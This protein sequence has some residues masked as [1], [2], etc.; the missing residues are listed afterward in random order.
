MLFG[1]SGVELA[2]IIVFLCLITGIMSGFPVA[3]ALGGSAL[4]SFAII[5]VMN[6]NGLLLT[7]T[8]DPIIRTGEEW[9]IFTVYPGSAVSNMFSRIFGGGNVDVLLAVPLFVFMGIT[10]ERSHIADDLL[11]TMAKVFGPLPGGLA[12]SVVMVGAL[13]AASTGIVGAT[14]VTMGLLSLPTMLNKGYSPEL[15][16]GTICASGTLG[17][18]IPPSIVLVLLGQQV[19]EYYAEAHPGTVVS[20]GTLF[21]AAIIPGFMLVALYI[22]YIMWVAL[23]QPHKAPAVHD[24]DAEADLAV[25]HFGGVKRFLIT[26]FVPLIG[27]FAAWVILGMVGLTGPQHP[28]P[29]VEVVDFVA[30]AISPS[31]MALLVLVSVI[32]WLRYVLFP[33][34]PLRPLL[35]GVLG[36]VLLAAVSIFV[37]QPGMSPSAA[38][39]WYAVPAY[40]M[41]RGF[42]HAAKHLQHN[43][44]IRVAFPPIVL[45]VAVLGSIL[46]G[47]T[48]PTAAAGLGAGGAIMLAAARQLKPG[49]ASWPIL[50]AAYAIVLLLLISNNFDIRLLEAMTAENTLAYALAFLLYHLAF[51]GILYCIYILWVAHTRRGKPVIFEISLETMKITSMVFVILI[52]SIMLN[53]VLKSFGGDHYIQEVL[54]SFENERSVLLLVL[55]VIFIMG[56]MLDFLE[57]IYIVIPIVG[58]VIYGGDMD[59]KWVTI[60]IAVNLQTSFLTPPFGFALFYLRGVAPKSVT[61]M[62]IYRGVAPFVL[63]QVLALAI[64]WFIEPISTFLPNL[65]PEGG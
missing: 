15:A 57:I 35:M 25:A 40:L 52:G 60:L 38:T 44:V 3:Y 55:V 32:F 58:P 2:I 65:L 27:F 64:L 59:P 13:L 54:R 18:I 45:I 30:P 7:A 46:G 9:K 20:V 17:Q 34:E 24:E 51:A 28:R 61:T 10:L 33:S 21:K 41:I 36:L 63:I 29:G 22:A 47:V 16:T 53:L 42:V 37:V 23:T 39:I 19:G 49:Q 31:I 8:G 26:L 43:D 14:V 4:I 11:T 56:F 5:V 62:H 50:W 1:L 12:V 6:Q 48:N